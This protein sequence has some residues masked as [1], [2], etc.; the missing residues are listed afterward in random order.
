MDNLKWNVISPLSDKTIAPIYCGPK[1]QW[2]VRADY[3]EIED[4]TSYITRIGTHVYP[5]DGVERTDEEKSE[6]YKTAG[7]QAGKYI[8]EFIVN[9]DVNNVRLVCR[10]GDQIKP[11]TNFIYKYEVKPIT[12]DLSNCSW[13]YNGEPYDKY[14]DTVK[15]DVDITNLISDAVFIEDEIEGSFTKSVSHELVSGSLKEYTSLLN[16]Y[17]RY[18]SWAQPEEV[19]NNSN[20]IVKDLNCPRDFDWKI[21]D[22]QG[23]YLSNYF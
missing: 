12:V 5:D 17:Y 1:K 2:L 14:K 8:A 13:Y 9:Y 18:I 15:P 23:I 3:S 11:F 22:K 10:D 19:Y 16:L 6:G 7:F 21:S 4:I 20:F